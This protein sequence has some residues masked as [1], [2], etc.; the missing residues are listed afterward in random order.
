MVIL[1]VFYLALATIAV[2]VILQLITFVVMKIMYPPEPKVI[3]QQVPVYQPPV[4][5]PVQPPAQ[6]L[7]PPVTTPVL[8]QETQEVQLPEYEPRKPTATSLRL[9]PELPA[10]LQETRPPGT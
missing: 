10:G 3:Y 9:D 5:I 6:P 8:R 2:M 1:D 7:F 4:Q